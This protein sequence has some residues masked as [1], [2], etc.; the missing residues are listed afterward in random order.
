MRRR[1][2]P[3]ITQKIVS[4]V[5]II[6]F[7]LC[8]VISIAGYWSFTTQF[9]T[10]YDASVLSISDA[11]RETLNKDKLFYYAEQK[12]ADEEYL[13]TKVIL[14]DFVDKFDLNLLYVSIVDPPEYSH[15]TYIFNPVKK[16]GKWKEFP[17]GYEEDYINEQYS[18]SIRRVY[19][20]GEDMVRHTFN[21]RSGSHI[22]ANVPVFDKNGKVIAVVGAQK[23]VQEFV[24]G[25]HSYLRLILVVE[26]FFAIAFIF[27]FS[28][29]FNK[30]FIHPIM[31]IT[32]ETD[33]F[34][35]WGGE[36][37]DNLLNI[38]NR[39]ELGILAHTVHQMEYDVCN[40]IKALTKVTA[41]KERI[42]TELNLAAKIQLDALPKGYPPFPDRSDFDLYG[43]MTPAKE[44]GG[45]LF[46][47]VLLDQD[48]L[49]LVVGDVSGKGVPAALF[50]MTAKTLIS[51]YAEQ[52]LSPKE[53]FERT[54]NQ[55]C[56]G[57][58]ENLFVTCWLGIFTFSRGEL[59]YV[60][61]GHPFPVLYQNKKFSFLSEKPNFVLGGMEGLPY[62]E[63]SITLGKGDRIFV[64][65]DGV[66]EATN[67]E[68]KLFGDDRLLEAVQGSQEKNAPDTLTQIQ[69]Q[70]DSFVG[71]ADQ[72][73]DITMLQFIV[74]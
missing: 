11:V 61:A 10:Q 16:G 69:S 52:G 45:D 72:F 44:V 9:K 2:I 57:N 74:K 14:Q 58:E 55:L 27:G 40:N 4:A 53:I 66:T 35:S 43:N 54:N 64:Y 7:L 3:I 46:D 20:Y 17:I 28:A 22:T 42:S 71:E 36:P 59:K 18:A 26:I 48:H 13:R 38:K 23:P 29:Y 30:Y 65:T 73:D 41:E 32:R 19:E 21:N 12:T 31:M 47:Y 51:S 8:T 33:H 15:I 25:R 6:G 70:I 37:S 24:N 1:R 60:N 56:K 39:D 34:A 67:S 50:M 63:Y 5:I 68:E 49:M 62:K